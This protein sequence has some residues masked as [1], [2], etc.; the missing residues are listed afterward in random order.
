MDLAVDD[1]LVLEEVGLLLE[2]AGLVLEDAGLV[3]EEAGLV[4]E[5]AGLVLEEAGF[6]VDDEAGLLLEVEAGLL[7][8][9][10]LDLAVD[11]AAAPDEDAPELVHFPKRGL[12]PVPQCPS[13]FPHHPYLGTIRK[14]PMN[15]LQ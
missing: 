3:L 14:I 7:D 1:A 9:T 10:E 15:C 6:V 12:H 2:E 11:E 5:E 13:V 8:D 4:L